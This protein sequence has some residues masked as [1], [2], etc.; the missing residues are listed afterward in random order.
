[1]LRSHHRITCYKEVY[2]VGCL[3]GSVNGGVW[4]CLVGYV[5]VGGLGVVY[6]GG[7]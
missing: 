1:M 7:P 5:L 6:G 2:L 4:I 3:S